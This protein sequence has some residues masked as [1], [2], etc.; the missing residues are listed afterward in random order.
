[1]LLRALARELEDQVAHELAARG[2]GE[3][4]RLSAVVLV[5][6]VFVNSSD[7]ADVVSLQVPEENAVVRVP[8][9]VLRS[10]GSTVVLTLAAFNK[11]ARA[12]FEQEERGASLGG[13]PISIRLISATSLE[14]AALSD[15]LPENI[16][17][18]LAA[19]TPDVMQCGFWDEE[20]GGGWSSRGLSTRLD[21]DGTLICS[22]SHLT[23]FA[24]IFYELVRVVECSNVHVFSDSGFENV[25]RGVWAY[26]AP[27]LLLWVVL[28]AQLV[29]LIWAMCFDCRVYRRSRWRDIDFLTSNTAFD[30]DDSCS[31]WICEQITRYLP[32]ESGDSKAEQAVDTG[33]FA[34]QRS[35]PLTPLKRPPRG[36]CGRLG[37][38]VESVSLTIT[39]DCAFYQ[40]ARNEKI[41]PYD[42]RDYIVG[43]MSEELVE[44]SAKTPKPCNCGARSCQECTRRNIQ[45]QGESPVGQHLMALE[46]TM[47]QTANAV[48][49]AIHSGYPS[50]V[51]RLWT[52]SG[53]CRRLWDMFAA[54]H[55]WVLMG[56]F[57]ITIG[58]ST[59]VVLLSAKVCGA[60]MLSALFFDATGSATSIR[61][62]SDCDMHNVWAMFFRNAIIGILS[63]LLSLIP[64][65]FILLCSN[66]RFVYRDQ[67]DDRAK[68][69]YIWCWRVQD[70][71][72]IL[73]SMSYCGCCVAYVMA[74]LASIRTG[75]GHEWITSAIFVLLREFL[76]TP[77][78]LAA[79]YAT[80]A[81]IVIHRRPDRDGY[82]KERLCFELGLPDSQALEV[83]DDILGRPLDGP[84]GALN[85]LGEEAP[86]P[87]IVARQP[88]RLQV[89]DVEEL[90]EFTKATPGKWPGVP[91]VIDASHKY[92]PCPKCGSTL[93]QTLGSE[94]CPVCFHLLPINP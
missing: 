65:L 93:W 64:L 76:L 74:F 38:L 82:V 78:A 40:V 51:E 59:R 79:L 30:R 87:E 45:Q 29:L 52:T 5:A 81:T 58:A 6:A 28:L 16:E 56:Q 90:G 49:A 35:R 50:T 71:F 15:N 61:S 41:A 86:L 22:T 54:L 11:T 44:P 77:M 73:V 9:G 92:V 43:G 24:A 39:H 17:F 63:S 3:L 46:R 33:G 75:A 34:R 31:A 85:A 69:G 42:L 60:L 18:E 21:A 88:P 67:W 27:A 84:K 48:A 19:K 68:R 89:E 32:E 37:A 55:P 53:F 10:A 94:I 57:S 1:M 83:A 20:A 12:S 91:R 36:C 66:R 14:D 4:K 13:P 2:S 26:Q 72:M 62:P 8:A 70:A 80:V 7:V 25:G 47:G 23:I